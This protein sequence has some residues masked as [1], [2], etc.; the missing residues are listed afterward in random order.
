MNFKRLAVITLSSQILSVTVALIVAMHDFGV[1]ALVALQVSQSFFNTFLLII[2]NR[3]IP[4]LHFSFH[5]FKEQFTF[6][7]PLLGANLLNVINTSVYTAI[8]G[9][10]Y[11]ISLTGY[12][13]QSLKLQTVPTNITAAVIDKVA[14]TMLS[15]QNDN[16]KII[17][18]GRKIN[19]TILNIVIPIFCYVILCSKEI[20]VFVLGEKW[21]NAS[22]IFGI[23]SFALIPT[24]IKIISRNLLKSGGFTKMIFKMEV[25]ITIIS[26]VLFS[27]A[28]L[29]SFKSILFSIVLSS[30]LSSC[31]VT[32][33]V[34]KAY[35]YNV[36]DQVKVYLYPL[37]ISL[38][39]ICMIKLIVFKLDYYDDF[40]NFYILLAYSGFV[41]L[42]YMKFELF[43]F[44][45]VFKK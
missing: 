15:K 31:V 9:K 26:F 39:A 32:Y 36:L 12:F 25:I 29:I 18:M 14:F 41:I 44:K 20:F 40:F 21:I 37:L 5:S 43:N 4:S 23:L 6:G 1:W 10:V 42:G 13:T 19:S 45:Y 33:F 28:L 3:Y 27:V 17:E 35:N 11:P 16:L 24:S 22:W 38:A 7:A 30:V 8:I 34:S 2:S